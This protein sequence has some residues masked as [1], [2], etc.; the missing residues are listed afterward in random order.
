MK[1]AVN[2]GLINPVDNFIDQSGYQEIFSRF[3]TMDGQT[4]N[5]VIDA[6]NMRIEGIQRCYE[7]TKCAG[8]EGLTEKFKKRDFQS[9]LDD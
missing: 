8:V 5:D 4:N 9:V 3:A 2:S 6:D 7:N 1:E